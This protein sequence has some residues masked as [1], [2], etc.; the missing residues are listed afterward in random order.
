MD[1]VPYALKRSGIYSAKWR[2]NDADKDDL[3]QECVIAVLKAQPA[4]CPSRGG[5]EPYFAR[6]IHH[7]ACA[8]KF[9]NRILR[10]RNHRCKQQPKRVGLRDFVATAHIGVE[11]S[12]ESLAL[13]RLFVKQLRYLDRN[14][15]EL[16]VHTL[17]GTTGAELA[18]K[19]G[20][21]K[22]RISDRRK[23]LIEKL[24]NLIKDV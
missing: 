1:I 3:E 12:S 13:L 24:R 7:A 19:K 16:L 10:K 2:L 14:S 6:V 20:L 18:K 17:A 15:K 9:N 8:W 23:R 22:Q 11:N 4:Y 21:T 5:T